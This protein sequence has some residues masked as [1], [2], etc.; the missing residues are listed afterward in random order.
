MVKRIAGFL[1]G[2]VLTAATVLASDERHDGRTLFL[3]DSI[4]HLGFCEYDLQ[5]VENLRHPGSERRY[6]NAGF[7]GGTLLTGIGNCKCEIDRVKPD[8]VVVMFGMNDVGWMAFETN[9]V[10]S[11]ERRAEADRRLA[12]YR[13]NYMRLLSEIRSHGVTNV[14]LATPTPYDEY[15][16]AAPAICRRNVNEYG[17]KEMAR[18]VREIARS[19]N[20]SCV[21]LHAPMTEMAKLHPEIAWC[22]GDRVHPER[23]GYL[24]MSVQYLAAFGETARISDLILTVD[25]EVIACVN[26]TVDKVVR[27]E[28]GLSFD[29]HPHALPLPP[30]PEYEKLKAVYPPVC[31]FNQEMLAVKGLDEGFWR[32]LADGREIG[33]FSA[34]QFADGVNL[35]E[36]DTSNRRLAAR[37]AE[38]M[39][40]LHDFDVPRRNCA[41]VRRKYESFG[42]PM[43]DKS[44][45]QVA[46]NRYL[47]KLKSEKYEWYGW[48]ERTARQ[49]MDA[50]GCEVEMLAEEERLYRAMADIRPVYL[51]IEIVKHPS[52]RSSVQEHD[53]EKELSHERHKKSL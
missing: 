27:T 48:E 40:A 38:A 13:E 41:C 37:A 12:S 30:L 43:N 23:L 32:L 33:V 7:G 22:G 5:L 34:R 28:R 11:T 51:K 19:E 24:F 31:Q 17:L 8:R 21:D 47:E 16:W 6:Y 10:L 4:T 50:M 52:G 53:R 9:V 45:L 42:V 20:L 46:V 44:A 36:L 18:I 15:S 39:T 29:Y 49:F 14:V 2:A 25:G 1:A 35:G 26:A 3:G